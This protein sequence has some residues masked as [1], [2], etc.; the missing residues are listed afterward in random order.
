MI[1][2]QQLSHN[3]K[4]KLWREHKEDKFKQIAGDRC[5]T[6]NYFINNNDIFGFI[7]PEDYILYSYSH[8]HSG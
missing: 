7:K 4:L 3:Q 5:A 2:S 1:N 8:I 6:F